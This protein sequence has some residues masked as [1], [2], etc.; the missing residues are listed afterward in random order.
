MSIARFQ[1]ELMTG[2]LSHKDTKR[3]FSRF[4]W[5]AFSYF[6]ITNITQTAIL[7]AVNAFYPSLASNW[8]FYELLSFIPNYCV[9]LPLS[10]LFFLRRLPKDIPTKEKMTVGAWCRGFCICMTLMTV[11]SDISQIFLAVIES[12]IGQAP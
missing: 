2:R 10:F 8:L 12:Y 11:G 7:L 1:P 3:Y 4:G 9:G 6:L 5:F